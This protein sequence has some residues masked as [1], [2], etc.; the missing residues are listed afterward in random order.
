[1]PATSTQTTEPDGA[2]ICATFGS[3]IGVGDAGRTE[4]GTGVGTGVGLAVGVGLAAATDGLGDALGLAAGGA[5]HATMSPTRTTSRR[6]T[7]LVSTH[8]GGGASEFATSSIT[9]A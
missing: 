3:T 7:P 5:E 4:V 9:P 1:V 2:L 6:I 8:G